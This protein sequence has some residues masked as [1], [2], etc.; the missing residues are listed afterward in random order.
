MNVKE[1]VERLRNLQLQETRRYKSQL[2]IIVGLLFFLT[3]VTELILLFTRVLDSQFYIIVAVFGVLFS[4]IAFFILLN[5]NNQRMRAYLVEEIMAVY[6]R[7]TDANTI[8]EIKPK[9]TRTFNQEM[10][11][12]TRGASVQ[13]DYL[14]KIAH[15]DLDCEILYCRLITS[16]GKSS[17]IHFNGFYAIFQHKSDDFFQIRSR[18]KPRLKGVKFKRLIRYPEKVF[19]PEID[20]REYLE[21]KYLYAFRNINNKMLLG[22]SYLASNKEAV[23]LALSP[24]GN[25]RMPK[26]IDQ[27]NFIDNYNR[28]TKLFKLIT[29]TFEAISQV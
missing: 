21:E 9:V 15:K 26:L 14:V 5:S 29:S 3:G 25:F 17:T 10:G 1:N 4:V 8:L 16:N 13:T 27:E 18:G 20:I 28:Y 19:I 23:H 22:N 6:N 7:E 2:A 12:F 11:L 24:K